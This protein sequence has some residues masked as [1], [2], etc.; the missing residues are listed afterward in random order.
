M[1]RN[2]K[3]YV[4]VLLTASLLGSVAS[5]PTKANAATTTAR[6]TDAEKEGFLRTAKV[7]ES[8]KAPVGVTRSDCATLSD[9]RLTHYAHV[10]SV[11]I[12][13]AQSQTPAGLELNCR[14]SY[15]Y[16]VVAYKLDRLLGL[17][18]VPVS[19]ER[20]VAG[21]L[22]AVTWWCDNIMMM[23]KA[24]YTKKI[25]IPMAK[26]VSWNDQMYQVR[27]FNELIYNTDAN[28]GNVL[29]T[30]DWNIRIVD[31]SR[32]FRTRR[33]LRTPANL[34]RCDRRRRRVAIR[35]RRGS[36]PS[37]LEEPAYPAAYRLRRVQK[38]PLVF[39]ATDK[40]RRPFSARPANYVER[41]EQAPRSGG[42][43]YCVL[44]P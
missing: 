34:V 9:G 22:A 33:G 44:R 15:K 42:G 38:G 12:Q 10:Q 6:L 41:C 18:M 17:N 28:L 11:D 39:G 31:F 40:Q 27:I 37:R 35:C 1:K 16:N 4:P 30:N 19:M 5:L 26:R 7:V 14:D 20:K 21:D 3:S 24:R 8:R 2:W 43:W 25:Q 29:I 32:G 13:K 23:D 36:M